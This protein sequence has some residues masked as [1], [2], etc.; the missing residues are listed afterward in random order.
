MDIELPVRKHAIEILHP[1]FECHQEVKLTSLNGEKLRADLLAVSR[2]HCREPVVLAVEVKSHQNNDP[3]KYKDALFQASKYVNAKIEDSKSYYVD[4]T[5]IDAA[6]VFPAPDYRWY[7][8]VSEN[9]GREHVLTG[10][11]F[12][13]ERLNVGRLVRRGKDWEIAFGSNCFWSR[14][15]GWMGHAKSRF[16]TKGI[17]SYV[18]I[19]P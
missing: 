5:S 11:A 9:D 17:R 2:T 16:P 14:N 12:F 6:F 13:A 19:E 4:V 1:F 3:G 18:E 8:Q 15:K 10:V 7:G